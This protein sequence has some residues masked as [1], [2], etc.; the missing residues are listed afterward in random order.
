MFKV[1]GVAVNFFR[2]WMYRYRRAVSIKRG[3]QSRCKYEKQIGAEEGG[4]FLVACPIYNQCR[5]SANK[6]E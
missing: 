6:E 1:I 4:T 2:K 3:T 5:Y